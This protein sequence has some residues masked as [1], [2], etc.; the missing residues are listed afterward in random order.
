MSAMQR[1]TCDDCERKSALLKSIEMNMASA[2][3]ASEHPMADE[4][5]QELASHARRAALAAQDDETGD[6]LAIRKSNAKRPWLT[7]DPDAL[8][9]NPFDAF[10]L[11]GGCRRILWP[12]AASVNSRSNLT[13][14]V[15]VCYIVGCGRS[16]TTALAEL[17][18]RYVGVV[19]VNE[20]RQLWIPLLPAMD[21]W[22][23]A[24]PSRGG[25]LCFSPDEALTPVRGVETSGGDAHAGATQT[26]AHHVMDAYTT[27]AELATSPPLAP[28]QTSRPSLVVEKFPEHAFRLPFLANMCREELGPHRCTILHIIRDGVDTARSIAAFENPAAWYGVKDE[29]KWRCLRE[30]ILPGSDGSGADKVGWLP[31]CQLDVSDEF[32]RYLE[33]PRT[34][35]HCRFARG[36]AEW[37]A[38]VLAARH[39]AEQATDS[40]YVEV[41][42][43]D[44]IANPAQ[45]LASLTS[46]LDLEPSASARQR[47][48]DLLV[49]R[50]SRPLTVAER[51]VLASCKGSRIE[52]LLQKLGR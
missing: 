3:D 42:Y 26:V 19:F 5:R 16:G 46:H 32:V 28:G 39:G 52:E 37:A 33:M 50:P 29:W 13:L 7:Y 30:I 40:Q 36:L 48:K 22:S 17:M 38:S 20:P 43:E 9:P 1:C 47:A 18:S 45:A 35:E 49:A 41:R 31:H 12:S 27:I 4:L 24:A 51:E 6:R 10:L 2:A 15:S 44:L 23:V 25:K 14:E 8:L 21:V 11:G 34:E